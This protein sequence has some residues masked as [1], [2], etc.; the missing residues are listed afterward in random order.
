VTHA[1]RLKRIAGQLVILLDGD[2]DSKALKLAAALAGR[3]PRYRADV[4]E[5]LEALAAEASADL[6]L[7]KLEVLVGDADIEE[8]IR[9]LIADQAFAW[10]AHGK[11]L[12]EFEKLQARLD[13]AER[14][15]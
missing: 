3:L 4:T 12:A 11:L 9:L 6:R 5:L 15:S 14:R 7:R 13:A 10:D 2:Q 1:D 8:R